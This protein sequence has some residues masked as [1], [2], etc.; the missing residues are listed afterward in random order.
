MKAIVGQ[1]SASR[2]IKDQCVICNSRDEDR[3]FGC[4]ERQDDAETN[5]RPRHKVRREE[6]ATQGAR[7]RP[8][9]SRLMHDNS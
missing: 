1:E 8:G 2:P 6:H 4:D 3:N 5:R 9:Q 7:R